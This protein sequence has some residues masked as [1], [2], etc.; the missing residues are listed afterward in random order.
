MLIWT[1]TKIHSLQKWIAAPNWTNP[2]EAAKGKRLEDTGLWILEEHEFNAWED[3]LS[4]LNEGWGNNLLVITGR[5]LL[6]FQ[7][8]GNKF[9]C[10]FTFY[11]KQSQDTERQFCRLEL[12][13]TCINAFFAIG[14]HQTKLP[15]HRASRSSFLT[16]KK[17]RSNLTSQRCRQYQLSFYFLS[18]I[19]K[20]LSTSRHY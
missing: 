12:S 19:I 18:G 13:N 11:L 10:W 2:F 7:D 9:P 1:E 3:Q 17:Q 5:D 16:N 8:E 14:N 4:G 15:T 6:Y 20:H